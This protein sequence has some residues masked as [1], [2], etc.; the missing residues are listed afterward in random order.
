MKLTRT[1]VFLLL[2]CATTNDVFAQADD[3]IRPVGYECLPFEEG[4]AE[5]WD[6]LRLL[7]PFFTPQAGSAKK[8]ERLLQV[9][10]NLSYQYFDRKGNF[11]QL[12]TLNNSSNLVQLQAKVIYKEKYPFDLRVRYNHIRP[13]QLDNLYEI[14]WGFDRNAY[15]Q[16]LLKKYEQLLD[17]QYREEYRK[18][19]AEYE[20]KFRQWQRAKQQYTGAAGMQRRIEG[21]LRAMKA[22]EVGELPNLSTSAAGDS[23]QALLAS[24][25]WANGE[26][27][28]DTSWIRKLKDLQA[29]T[30]GKWSAWEDSLLRIYRESEQSLRG[31]KQTYR[32][33]LDSLQQK[34]Q[35]PANLETVERDMEDSLGLAR[36]KQSALKSLLMRS[37]FR[38][39]K[40]LVNMSELT[41]NNIFLHG[42]SVR[43]GDRNYVEVAAGVYDFAF[44]EFLRVRNDSQSLGRPHVLAVRVGRERQNGSNAFTVYAGRKTASA[45]LSG[46]TRQVAGFSY[47]QQWLAGR[48]W[49]FLLELA[50]STARPL[51]AADKGEGNWRE[52]LT[53]FRKETVAAMGRVRGVIRKTNTDLELS[54][55]YWGQQFESF[56]ATQVFN[57]QNQ[58]R[59][60]ARQPFWKKRLL[61]SAGVRY[62]DFRTVGVA[63]NLRSRTLFTSTTI[64]ARLPKLP[65]ISLGY[66]P[67]SQLYQMEGNKLYE[68][69]YSILNATISHHWRLASV[70]MQATA[71]YNRFTNEYR[72]SLVA[73]PQDMMSLF[74]SAW[75]GPFTYSVNASQQRTEENQLQTLEGGLTWAGKRLRL[76]GSVKWNKL[77]ETTRW[78]GSLTAGVS[79]GKLGTVS[80]LFD[81]SFFPDRT[82]KFLPVTMGQI[83]YI[84]PLNF[85]IWR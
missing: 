44:R 19:R 45:S 15:K 31:L 36:E 70:S 73:P 9:E 85:S 52:L 34:L 46:A 30:T 18:K 71:S 11:D 27:I 39:G 6:A 62:S 60:Q 41:V 24:R 8:R 55:R 56:N 49:E 21:E 10:G 54:F 58:W 17:N 83:Q 35:N 79:F 5:Y 4:S 77:S 25:D 64:V 74:L 61:V 48:D 33:K 42:G 13:F 16:L 20:A 59:V 80:Y 40:F 65:V 26:S 67:G 23:L 14:N 69:F 84:K 7:V 32:K 12:S 3:G 68:Y 78:A 37:R 47:E 43:Y 72:D 66:Y 57:P 50:K 75:K 81:K 2:C 38:A 51:T 53:S 63:S 28:I 76:G 82:G 1:I 29:N 22:K